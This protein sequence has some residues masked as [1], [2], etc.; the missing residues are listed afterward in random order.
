MNYKTNWMD[1]GAN[2]VWW[3]WWWWWGLKKYLLHSS[4]IFLTLLVSINSHT[5]SVKVTKADRQTDGQTDRCSHFV[6]MIFAVNF[7][8]IF[9]L[10]ENCLFVSLFLLRYF[11]LNRL[12]NSGWLLVLSKFFVLYLFFLNSFCELFKKFLTTKGF[13]LWIWF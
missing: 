6:V 3:W 2:R 13:P 8:G 9:S 12:Y 11:P 10:K 7:S 1:G 5:A 4:T